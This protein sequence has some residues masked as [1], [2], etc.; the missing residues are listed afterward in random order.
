MNRQSVEASSHVTGSSPVGI[1]HASRDNITSCVVGAFSISMR[2]EATL[3]NPRGFGDAYYLARS[4]S[5]KTC[6]LIAFG[7]SKVL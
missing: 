2:V 7:R 3:Q 1:A 4:S 6:I 5:W